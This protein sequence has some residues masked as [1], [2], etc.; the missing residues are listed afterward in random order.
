MAASKN[1]SL[2]GKCPTLARSAPPICQNGVLTISTPRLL[3]RP[4]AP[5]DAALLCD[6]A[7]KRR[8]AD[9]TISI[10]HPYTREYADAWIVKQAH[11]A[12]PAAH[13]VHWAIALNDYP[14]ALIGYTCIKNID[15]EHLEGELGFWLDEASGGQGYATEAAAATVT[16]AFHHLG[17]NRICAHHMVRNPASQRVLE[18]IGMKL[19]G[20]LRQRVR[21]WEVFED[22][23]L[24][25]I[26]REEWPA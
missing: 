2:R 14:D 11:E 4:F 18:R 24:W 12:G 20:R 15:R 1:P 6:L 25:S 21:K 5:S 19:E 3:L 9:T 8:I 13:T 7:G 23:L 16:Y 17:L 22:V 26:L 10:P